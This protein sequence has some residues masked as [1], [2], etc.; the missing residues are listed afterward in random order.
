MAPC[1]VILPYNSA[2]YHQFTI[3]DVLKKSNI[4]HNLNMTIA[5]LLDVLQMIERNNQ[6]LTRLLHEYLSAIEAS[7]C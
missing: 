3:S 2:R 1:S 6:L 4:R 5:I 7:S